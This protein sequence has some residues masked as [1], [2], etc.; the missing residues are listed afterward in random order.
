ME[1][2]TYSSYETILIIVKLLIFIKLI[3]TVQ[4]FFSNILFY[5]LLNSNRDFHSII[6]WSLWLLTM[7]LISLIPTGIFI[8][9]VINIFDQNPILG[10]ISFMCLFICFDLLDDKIRD[11]MD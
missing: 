7:S 1:A 6:K 9:F 2:I 3:C 8:I 11:K 5:L 10:F 4:P